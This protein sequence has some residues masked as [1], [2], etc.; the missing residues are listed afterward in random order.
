MVRCT[1]GGQSGGKASPH[2]VAG[3][4]EG[5]S[6]TEGPGPVKMDIWIC[7]YNYNGNQLLLANELH[8]STAQY[9]TTSRIVVFEEN[10]D[11]QL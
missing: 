5:A 8:L 11:E 9:S 3:T 4:N 2:Y 6:S 10:V 1:T 7:L